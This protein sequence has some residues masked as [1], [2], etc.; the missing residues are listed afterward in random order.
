MLATFHDNILNSVCNVLE[1]V[2]GELSTIHKALPQE[3]QL[4]LQ[5]F[6][7]WRLKCVGW[8]RPGLILI[9]Q[10]CMANDR[11]IPC[12]NQGDDQRPFTLPWCTTESDVPPELLLGAFL[13]CHAEV[14]RDALNTICN[15]VI[16][17]E[18]SEMSSRSNGVIKDEWNVFPYLSS[19]RVSRSSWFGLHNLL[20]LGMTPYRRWQFYETINAEKTQ[21]T[22]PEL[23][24]SELGS[25]NARHLDFCHSTFK[26][27]CLACH[28]GDNV[29]FSIG[30]RS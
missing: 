21:R 5:H 25:Y 13:W 28:A 15:L 24:F 8:H 10:T 12:D 27:N 23:I 26:W 7:K 9:C 11:I 2:R 30:C 1:S 19:P 6:W 17:A 22:L 3:P 29:S 14:C 4:D 18:Q 16:K 20:N